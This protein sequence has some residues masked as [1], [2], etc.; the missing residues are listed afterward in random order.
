[1]YSPLKTLVKG[2]K[3]PFTW[4]ILNYLIKSIEKKLGC[5]IND[6]LV[7]GAFISLMGA[8]DALKNF[9]KNKEK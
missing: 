3:Y 1:M 7:E 9:I 6:E 4:L 8:Y 5:D 2:G